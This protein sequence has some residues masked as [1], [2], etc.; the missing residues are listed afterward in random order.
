[1]RTDK[2]KLIMKKM[3]DAYCNA[4]E[5]FAL[6]LT[7]TPK[8]AT[9]VTKEAFRTMWKNSS[10]RRKAQQ[11][12][13]KDPDEKFQEIFDATASIEVEFRRRLKEMTRNLPRDKGGR[14]RKVSEEMRRI[15]EDEIHGH[16]RRMD[17]NEALIHVQEKHPDINLRYLE[18]I[19]QER[20]RQP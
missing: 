7:L 19:W 6:A 2:R 3:D 9:A 8:Q 17:L 12:L 14:P 18:K 20:I 11:A 16:T 1:M 13:K 5:R 10:F 15:V 4:F